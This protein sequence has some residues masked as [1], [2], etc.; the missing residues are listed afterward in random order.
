MKNFLDSQLVKRFNQIR[1]PEARHLLCHAPFKN[2]YFGSSG[3]VSAC[4][5]N[6]I[7]QLG[8]YPEQSISE[9]LEGEKLN[10]LSDHIQAND[11]SLGC[12]GCKQ[13]IQAANF[14]AVKAKQYDDLP[15]NPNGYPSVMEFELSNV[16]NLECTMCSGEY[17]SLIR[18]NREKRPGLTSPYK[19]EFVK[20]LREYIPYLTETKFYGGEPFLIGI[21]LRIW[22]TIMRLNPKCRISVQTNATTLN[23]RIKRL[24]DQAYFH[25]NV[26]IDSLEKENF[27]KIRVNADFG[28]V[29][30][31]IN[32]L[33][34]YC[35]QR[36]TFFG[37]SVC[38]MRQNWWEAPHFIRFCNELDIPVY[39]HTVYFPMNCSIHNL[40]AE[41]IK[42]MLETLRK[43]TF[44]TENPIQKLNFEKYQGLI[45][46]LETWLRNVSNVK[47]S[48]FVKNYE[49]LFELMRKHITKSS[50]FGSSEKSYKIAQLRKKLQGVEAG[51]PKSFNVEIFF[52][53]LDFGDVFL[54]ENILMTIENTPVEDLIKMTIAWKDQL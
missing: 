30:E 37:L 54:L 43:E 26:S 19:E 17:S 5:Y 45:H 42:K 24:L 53:D 18:K 44:P 35:K 16:C 11:L 4:C 10:R 23:P 20:E 47:N 31:N 27:E 39:F 33:R 32:Y 3:I 14:A 12:Q 52:A 9:I 46:Q 21:Y 28:T 2:M 50:K 8:K 41:E 29:M 15:F 49:D 13:L 7:H 25:I 22:E 40:P 34:N 51:L 6:R 1:K 38:F 48:V 36:K